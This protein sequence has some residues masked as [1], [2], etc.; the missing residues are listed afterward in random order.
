MRTITSA[1][2]FTD[3]IRAPTMVFRPGGGEAER[4]VTCAPH[5]PSE[6]GPGPEGCWGWAI[7]RY[8]QGEGGLSRVFQ[9][10]A[11]PSSAAEILS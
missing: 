3:W 8:G 5:C 4:G 10:K 9:I 1:S 7:M 6:Q 2:F 11:P